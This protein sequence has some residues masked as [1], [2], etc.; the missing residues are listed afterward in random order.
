MGT[1]EDRSIEWDGQVIFD[2][3]FGFLFLCSVISCLHGSKG[4]AERELMKISPSPSPYPYRPTLVPFLSS[5][6]RGFL[7]ILLRLLLPR[8]R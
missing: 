3:A 7:C 1:L 4:R 2:L 5:R 8:V 6:S